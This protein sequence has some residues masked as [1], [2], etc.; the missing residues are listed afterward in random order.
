MITI[1]LWYKKSWKIPI[2]ELKQLMWNL[3]SDILRP[4][5]LVRALFRPDFRNQQNFRIWHYWFTLFITSFPD[6]IF[7]YSTL[8]SKVDVIDC[9]NEDSTLSFSF[10]T[11]MASKSIIVGNI[12]VFK[13]LNICQLGLSNENFQFNDFLIIW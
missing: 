10:A 6:K 7:S 9:K 3:K 2:D 4:K 13:D 5:T 12:S 11:L 1:A 8:M